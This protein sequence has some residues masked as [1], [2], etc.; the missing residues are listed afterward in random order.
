MKR[1]LNRLFLPAVALVLLV[2]CQVATAQSS[3]DFIALV[4]FAKR[5]AAAWSSG[6]PNELASLYAEDGSLTVND[7]EPTVGRAAIAEMARGY[8][9]AFPD[10]EVEMTAMQ[11]SGSGAEFH[12]RWTGTNS[13]PGGTGRR[14]DLIGYE[15]WTFSSD[16]LIQE[17]NGHFDEALYRAQ[18]GAAQPAEQASQ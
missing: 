4:D 14:I 15:E 8:M 1:P 7:G 13:G 12:W 16:D 6:D 11:G 17:S 2:F 3:M 10:M 5:Y 18:V 9:E